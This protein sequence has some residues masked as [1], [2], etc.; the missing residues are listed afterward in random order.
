[1]AMLPDCVPHTKEQESAHVE[2]LSEGKFNNTE[3]TQAD[4][5][6]PKFASY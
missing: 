2:G 6:S 1:M 3:Q 5:D 4:S